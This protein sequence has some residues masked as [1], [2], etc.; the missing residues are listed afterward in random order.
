MEKTARW[1]VAVNTND[2]NPNSYDITRKPTNDA[3]TYL[4]Q[5]FHSEPKGIWV[6]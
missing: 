6:T 3:L 4:M 5:T 1:S 2:I